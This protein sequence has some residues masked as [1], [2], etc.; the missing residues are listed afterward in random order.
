MVSFGRGD[1]GVVV[2]VEGSGVD[3]EFEREKADA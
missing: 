3:F 2:V 1:V